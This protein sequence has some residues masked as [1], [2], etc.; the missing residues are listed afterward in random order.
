MH[1][2]TKKSMNKL[3]D[4]C[5]DVIIHKMTMN[6]GEV[7]LF[8]GCISDALYNLPTPIIRVFSFEPFE[9]VSVGLPDGQPQY[10]KTIFGESMNEPVCWKYTTNGKTIFLYTPESVKAGYMVDVKTPD[11]IIK[12]C[13]LN[14][15]RAYMSTGKK[16]VRGDTNYNTFMQTDLI[17]LC[18]KSQLDKQVINDIL[19]AE[20]R[21][22]LRLVIEL[23]KG[24]SNFLRIS[25]KMKK[26][27]NSNKKS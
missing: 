4:L 3:F 15:E 26:S 8:G 24:V 17:S 27:K 9:K 5:N 12:V 18:G 20:K 23:Q 11:D 6:I 22:N 7:Y 10:Q 25:S 16:E 1:R 21:Y 13:K 14:Y 2:F 19:K